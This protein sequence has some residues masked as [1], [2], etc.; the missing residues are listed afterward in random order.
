MTENSRVSFLTALSV[1]PTCV[2]LVIKQARGPGQDANQSA[3]SPRTFFS[4]CLKLDVLFFIRSYSNTINKVNTYSEF[5]FFSPFLE[6]I[7][8]LEYETN[9]H[10]TP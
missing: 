3:L 1:P 6:G 9:L 8:F 7:I 10:R 5:S 2:F 4:L